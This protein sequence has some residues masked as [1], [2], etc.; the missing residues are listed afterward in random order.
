[1]GG[2]SAKATSGINGACTAAQAAAGIAD[3]IE[4]FE[5]DTVASGH[6]LSK[7]ELVRVLAAQSA[8]AIDF[9]KSKGVPLDAVVQLG[10][11][12]RPRTH[13]EPP[14]ADGKPAPVGWD[15]IAALKRAVSETPSIT[16]VTGVEALA[17]LREGGGEGKGEG[18][19]HDAAHVT[20]TSASSADS[21][22][23]AVA[24]AGA[25]MAAG[26]SA[27]PGAAVTGVLFRRLGPAPAAAAAPAPGS[28]P[29]ADASDAV[30]APESIA[31]DAVVLA[32]GG[33][34]A[35]HTAH[36]LLRQ[37]APQLADLPTTNGAFA[38]GDGVRMAVAA[39]A[40]LEGM[41]HVQ[42]H[43]TGFADPSGAPATTVF[44]GPE[45]LRGY[46]GILLNHRG[47]RFV[48]ELDRRDAV[49]QAMYAHCARPV[50]YGGE[51]EGASWTERN[52]GRPAA[53][54]PPAPV[55]GYL[56]M[57]PAAAAK[58][59]PN[60]AFYK[61]KGF[62]SEVHGPA[63]VA[64]AIGSSASA[65][66]V[67]DSFAAYT[68]A[69]TG[70]AP[71]AY[72][73]TVFPDS[74]AGAT[75][76]DAMLLVAKVIPAIHYCMG[77]VAIAADTAV[78][79][80]DAAVM[81]ALRASAAAATAAAHASDAAGVVSEDAAAGGAGA[82]AGAGA[83]T[84]LGADAYL[85]LASPV[86]FSPVA[87][88]PVPD[89]CGSGGITAGGASTSSS[90]AGSRGFGCPITPFG[91][92]LKP[93][94][95]LFAAGEVT[96]GVHGGN[97]LAGNSLLECAVFGRIAG[98]RAAS[99]SSAGAALS[100]SD[101]TP[102]RLRESHAVAPECIVFRFDL[103]GPLQS[104]GMSPGQ[105]LAVRATIDGKETVRFYSPISRPDDVGHVDL[106]M[107]IDAAA[108]APHAGAAAGGG[109]G[110]GGGMTGHVGAMQ[111]GQTLEFKGPLGGLCVDF[112]L[113]GSGG[114]GLLPEQMPAGEGG[115]IVTGVGGAPRRIRK[116][117]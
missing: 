2:N 79:Y 19:H 50:S 103:P 86:P 104:L 80:E 115:V 66:A 51:S 63:G 110:G 11:H 40:A 41:E 88:S 1:M 32:T 93:I 13:H 25:G 6:G 20:A 111:P 23:A 108:R 49:S 10:G 7:P 57:T 72:G 76:D 28:G 30:A 45:A 29:G 97:R 48:N 27:R 9:L 112:S 24:L 95:R 60:F 70:G 56:V 17:L 67:A 114:C 117:G 21:S 74:F 100:P 116:L 83:G 3:S 53:D 59:G 33:F 77:G 94:P 98:A 87:S 96:G 39:G 54:A 18:N 43:P 35:D 85:G 26:A 109:G 5:A 73:K 14:R 65:A 12:S 102:L 31:A 68:A 84:G 99:V 81:A 92:G 91:T 113:D 15:I 106:L 22:S 55:I 47:A 16:V 69:A 75:N 36:S 89:A 64:A 90:G 101:F 38:R 105:Y 44:L 52:V 78:L 8:A 34:G 62:F 58:L 107:K 42:V 4:L 37:Y 46:G 71:D 61:A 82:G